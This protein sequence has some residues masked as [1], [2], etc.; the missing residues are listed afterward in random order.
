[1]EVE[2]HSIDFDAGEII[3]ARP[4]HVLNELCWK[5]IGAAVHEIDH[6]LTRCPIIA[7]RDGSRLGVQHIAAARV[8]GVQFARPSAA[9]WWSA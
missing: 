3:I 6:H 9:A 5:G 8:G 1:V 2:A 4:L 7:R